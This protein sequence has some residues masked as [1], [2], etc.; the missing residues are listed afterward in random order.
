MA[1]RRIA[2]HITVENRQAI[3]ST[4]QQTAATNQL[5]QAVQ[6]QTHLQAGLT[7]SFIKGNLAARAIS[8]TY[9]AVRDSI[10]DMVRTGIEFQFTM[11]KI[12]AISGEGVG[13]LHSLESNIR[14]M[15][16]TS[17]KAAPE[18]AAVANEMGKMGLTNKQVE[19][20]IDSVTTLG[21]AL[22]ENLVVAGET[23]VKVLNT[24]GLSVAHGKKITEQLAFTVA[25]SALDLEK[26]GT[27]FS[28]V[29]GTAAIAGVKFEDLA[30]AMDF[31]SNAGIKSSTIGTQLRRI[32]ADLANENSK[33]G[34]AIGGTATS[35]G[36]LIPALKKLD[37]VL[38]KD[39][40]K[41]IAVLTDM[42]GRT[43]TS[44]AALMIRNADAIADFS[45]RTT[46]A[47][48]NLDRM[49][50]IMDDTFAA[51][52]TKHAN[53][54]RELGMNIGEV[55]GPAAK[56]ALNA[57]TGLIA[58][59]ATGNKVRDEFYAKQF[60]PL[61]KKKLGMG[62]LRSLDEENLK[63]ELDAFL[64][65]QG[66]VANGVDEYA[67]T[68][69]EIEEQVKALKATFEGIQGNLDIDQ[70]LGKDV[71]YDYYIRKYEGLAESF[72]KLGAS[73]E[74]ASVLREIKKAEEE[75]FEVRSLGSGD[76]LKGSKRMLDFRTAVAPG[77][78][79]D[80]NFQNQDKGESFA[81]LK[82]A[83]ELFD[84][85]TANAIQTSTKAMKEYNIA[86]FEASFNADLLRVS[87]DGLNGSMGIFSTFLAEGLL[88]DKENPFKGISDAF[89][90]FA[91][92]MVADLIA[93][94]MRLLLFR[95][96]LGSLTGGA[97]FM[98]GPGGFFSMAFNGTGSG[99]K[100]FLLGALGGQKF[101][102]G[103][104]QI[105]R[106]PTA[107]IAGDG[108]PEKVKVTPRSKMGAGDGEGMTVINIH[109][110]VHD[111]ER[112]ARKVKNAQE[113]NRRNYV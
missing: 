22:D 45:K 38:P 102:S 37:E 95:V 6:G 65:A 43:A 99:A 14:Q 64:K 39:N 74:A 98:G 66:V 47:S 13:S 50:G 89:G 103:T 26:F 54:W 100:D 80:I 73:K 55:V 42:F 61:N 85:S 83:G 108:A 36:G 68:A 82:K 60:S 57:V 49:K 19:T 101:A 52:I 11:A 34:V 92:K 5:N 10:K 105:V 81:R 88:S 84:K 72:K 29:G 15:A 97:G 16:L 67:A 107:F 21:V 30:G 62:D 56:G 33:A 69:D 8:A 32:I 44:V 31:L 46:E 27:A 1:A 94:T 4:Q 53:A 25:A 63:A 109:G 2:I 58:A 71:D 91:K 79:E 18:I 3:V 51:S 76:D 110:D 86:L 90:D 87:V 40:D 111:Y 113:S 7:N 112:F 77:S 24:Y 35:V 41:R 20:L 12:H 93:L 70:L 59:L 17:M 106:T 78:Y 23:V 96:V 28:Y 104:D 9:L 48:G 75:L